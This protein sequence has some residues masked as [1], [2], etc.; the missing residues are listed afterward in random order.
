MR[1]LNLNY[2]LWWWLCVCPPQDKEKESFWIKFRNIFF[3]LVIIASL[4]I[5]FISGAIFFRD[6][7]FVNL[8]IALYSLLHTL[9]TSTQFYSFVV[10]YILRKKVTEIFSIYQEIFNRCKLR[11]LCQ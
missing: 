9:S 10:A 8:E 4:I 7:F 11:I 6:H 1:P 5:M 3:S 2:Q